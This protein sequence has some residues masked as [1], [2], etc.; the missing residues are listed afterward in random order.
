VGLGSHSRLSGSFHSNLR[1]HVPFSGNPHSRANAPR[2]LSHS[3]L[4]LNVANT[5]MASACDA[6][7][8]FV[9]MLSQRFA[10]PQKSHPVANRGMGPR[11]EIVLNLFECRYHAR[12][13]P[14]TPPCPKWLNCAQ[15][16][17]LEFRLPF[18]C[19]ARIT[20]VDSVHRTQDEKGAEVR[21]LLHGGGRWILKGMRPNRL[22]R[23]SN[24]SLA[25]QPIPAGKRCYGA[26][27]EDNG[28]IVAP[29]NQWSAPCHS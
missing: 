1:V 24:L 11:K 9:S 26:S 29:A 12:I 25:A 20:F 4:T 21:R 5:S 23:G 15:R 10:M 18:G 6:A 27:G 2:L 13:Q 28:T 3:A 14:E 22:S 17:N 7:V 8:L 16:M 19:Y